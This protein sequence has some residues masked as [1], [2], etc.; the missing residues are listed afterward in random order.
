MFMSGMVLAR[1]SPSD[2]HRHSSAIKTF[3]WLGTLWGGS[4]RFDAHAA[5]VSFVSM[6]VISGL[7]G[8][9]WPRRRWT[10]H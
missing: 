4:I 1:R 5:R 3:N 9:S 10:S 2:D 7:S 6:F 8:T